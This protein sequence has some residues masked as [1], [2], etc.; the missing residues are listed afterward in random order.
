MAII[1][2]GAAQAAPAA[3]S[4]IQ[5]ATATQW[6][7]A[8]RTHGGP[9]QGLLVITAPARNDAWAAGATTSDTLVL[10]HWNGR[11]WSAAS[12]RGMANFYPVAAQ[13]SAP[14]N[15]WLF[16]DKIV[17]NVAI[18]AALVYDGRSWQMRSLPG[19]FDTSNTAV[20]SAASVWGSTS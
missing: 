20:L 13:S 19:D 2:A 8:Y 18:Q 5:A 3:T 16:G 12:T 15:V 14:A 4:S 6:K 9:S 7:L 11:S 1:G 10:L 17:R